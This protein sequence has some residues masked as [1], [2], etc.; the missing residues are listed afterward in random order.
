M[1]TQARR[2]AALGEVIVAVFDKAA[3][4]STDP[5]EVARLATSALRHILRRRE[6]SDPTLRPNDRLLA[7]DPRA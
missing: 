2:T 3:L 5:R 1:R 4:Y 6:S 7:V